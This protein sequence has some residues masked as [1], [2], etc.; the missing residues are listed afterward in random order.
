MRDEGA[1]VQ[2]TLQAR[3]S[4]SLFILHPSAFILSSSVREETFECKGLRPYEGFRP[5]R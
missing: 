3:R 4:F 1:N 2:A 5:C